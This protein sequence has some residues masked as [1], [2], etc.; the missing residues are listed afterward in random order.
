M[1]NSITPADAQAMLTT[2]T[3]RIGTG[4]GTAQ[5]E[6]YTA[7]HAT[8][9]VEFDLAAT[10]FGTAT[11]PSAGSPSIATATGLPG[12]PIEGT[13]VADGDAG[14]YRI[15]DKDG[16]VRAEGSGTD[17]VNTASAVVILNNLSITNGQTVN[18]NDLKL[19]MPT[20]A[21]VHAI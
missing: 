21:T 7:S 20:T 15:K 4:S 12:T 8:L 17:A 1:A 18:L 6:I 5:V 2:L 11:T 19:A 13:A 16:T 3:G 14:A 10:P 9:L